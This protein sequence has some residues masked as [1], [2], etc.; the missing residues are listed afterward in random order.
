[1]NRILQLVSAHAGAQE[2]FDR[3]LPIWRNANADLLVACPQDAP[4]R[5]N[6]PQLLLG[7]SGHDGGAANQ[8]HIDTLL[9]CQQLGHEIVVDYDYDAFCLTPNIPVDL[10][11]S[12]PLGCL[13]VSSS[14]QP[15]FKAS[16]YC[17]PPVI[18]SREGLY[19]LDQHAG[20]L[21]AGEEEGFFDRWL[22]RL[23]WM[24]MQPV[25]SLGGKA[26]SRNT[27]E[28]ADVPAMMAAKA[29][30]CVFFHGCKTQAIFDLLT[31]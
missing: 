16:A 31:K 12:L 29:N 1:M 27:I 20:E 2:I 24:N 6:E 15:R 5:F 18:F 23:I 19:W 30:H 25:W 3:H 14:E 21:P 17:Q 26:F 10:I 8:R 4:V 28:E 11:G 7:A 13:L 22:G 9:W